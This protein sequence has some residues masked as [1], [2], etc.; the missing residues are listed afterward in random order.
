ML[1]IG[2]QH[3]FLYSAPA[4]MRRGFDGLSGLVEET[5][6]GKLLTGSVF[7]FVNRRRNRLK[8]LCWEG[9]GLAMYYKR[10]EKGTFRVAWGGHMA[11]TRRDFFMLV[12]GVVPQYLHK[13]Y[14]LGVKK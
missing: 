10:L 2:T 12:E 1:S 11:L 14:E 3:L 9:D 6:P 13:R 4:D 5:F 8:L 7:I